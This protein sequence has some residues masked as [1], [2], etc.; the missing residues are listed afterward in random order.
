MDD[1][2]E[3]RVWIGRD[4]GGQEMIRK[5]V[6]RDLRVVREGRVET[7]YTLEGERK[8]GKIEKNVGFLS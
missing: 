3:G 5:S 1:H 7:H 2:N 8:E 4:K 6:G